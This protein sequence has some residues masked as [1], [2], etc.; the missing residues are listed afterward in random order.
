MTSTKKLSVILSTLLVSFSCVVL[1]YKAGLG[2]NFV[3]FNLILSAALLG[4]AYI[5]K[6]LNGSMVTN[7]VLMSLMSFTYLINTSTIIRVVY[8]GIWSYFLLL[9]F[10]TFTDKNNKYPYYKYITVPIEQSVMGAIG[11]ILTLS[12]IRIT[13]SNWLNTAIRIGIGLAFAIPILIVFLGLLMSADL[14][15]R[16]IILNIFSVEFLKDLFN[17]TLIFIVTTWFMLGILF[18]NLYK[19]KLPEEAK[20]NKNNKKIE[21]TSRFFIEGTTILLLVELLFM[22][23]NVIQLTYMFGGEQLITSGGY[24]YSEYARK[25]F[26]E[27]IVVSVIALILIGF[28]LKIKKTDTTVKSF[29]M[30]G[31]GLFGLFLLLPMTLSSYYRLYLYESEYGFTR[32]RMYS[33]VFIVFLIIIF[34]WFAV[35]IISKLKENTFLYGIQIISLVALIITGFARFDSAIAYFNI[36]RYENDTSSDKELDVSYLYGLSYDTTPKLI[37]FFKRSEGDIKEETAFFL[38]SK[39]DLIQYV[40]KKSDLRD[41]NFSNEIAK[42][43]ILDN[44][45]EIVKYSNIYTQKVMDKYENNQNDA[46]FGYR[47]EDYDYCNNRIEFR[48]IS[49]EGHQ[50][51]LSDITIY[52]FNDLEKV[53]SNSF[54]TYEDCYELEPGKYILTGHDYDPWNPKEVFVFEVLGGEDELYF[55]TKD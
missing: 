13:K 44:W 5:S 1:F 30:K 18:Y 9:T 12:S 41:F 6:R 21:K 24:T 33:H 11:A 3:V 7:L 47:Y 8:F 48:F 35:K 14:A 2:L 42:N 19:K 10:G 20:N 50:D 39:Y 55:I 15:F 53:A 32:L 25:G 51:W 46:N 31:L 26:F 52:K 45:D 23:F 43:Q 28:I 29:V 17:L 38:R 27:L 16:E 49:R 36:K 40:E 4:S 54:H 34:I 37:D 22:I